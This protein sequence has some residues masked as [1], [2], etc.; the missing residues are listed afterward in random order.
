MEEGFFDLQD[1]FMGHLRGEDR[2]RW[3][4]RVYQQSIDGHQIAGNI[5]V[6]IPEKKNQNQKQPVALQPNIKLLMSSWCKFMGCKD[7][8]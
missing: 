3:R 1:S 4:F 7:W 5:V 6:D 8:L 2:R